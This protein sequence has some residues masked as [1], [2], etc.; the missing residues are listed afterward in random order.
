MGGKVKMSGILTWSSLG[1][2]SLALIPSAHAE[3]GGLAEAFKSIGDGI[4]EV[5]EQ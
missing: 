4:Q 3:E 2:L 5:T 1:A